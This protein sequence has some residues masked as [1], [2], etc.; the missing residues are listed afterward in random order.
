M[1][2]KYN[3]TLGSIDSTCWHNDDGETY[4]TGAYPTVNE[5]L[6]FTM[7]VDSNSEWSYGYIHTSVARI[8]V[9]HASNGNYEIVSYWMTIMAVS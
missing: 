1:S 4:I 6:T 9:R 5:N 8:G 2:L 7:G 3:P